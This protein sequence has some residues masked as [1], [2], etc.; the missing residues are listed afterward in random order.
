MFSAAVAFSV[1]S[2]QWLA[3]TLPFSAPFWAFWAPLFSHYFLLFR[4]HDLPFLGGSI[5]FGFF[6]EKKQK[7]GKNNG[8]KKGKNA[9]IKQN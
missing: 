2:F 4:G 6:P 1:A 7:K 3:G 5:F 9:K 8:P